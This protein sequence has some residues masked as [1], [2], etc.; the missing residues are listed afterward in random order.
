[1]RP[2]RFAQIAAQAEAVRL[3]RRVRRI[4]TQLVLVAMA[5]PFLL[6]CLGFLEVAFWSYVAKHFETE[7][8]ALVVLGGNLLVVVVLLGLALLRGSED[9][10]SL[11]ALEVRR[12]AIDSAQRSLTVATLVGPVT[13]FLLSQLRR[14]RRRGE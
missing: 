7:E 9:R 11:E 8:A 6:A 4:V 14:S 5:V 2:V 13:T 10:V 3:K 1:M 12:R